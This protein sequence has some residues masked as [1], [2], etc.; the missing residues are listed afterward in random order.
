MMNDWAIRPPVS[1][2]P[3]A[4]RKIPDIAE[5]TKHTTHG[6]LTAT[7]VFMCVR[8]QSS[9]SIGQEPWQ[10]SQAWGGTQAGVPWTQRDA[11]VPPPPPPT[12]PGGSGANR[13]PEGSINASYQREEEREQPGTRAASPLLTEQ[14]MEAAREKIQAGAATDSGGAKVMLLRLSN[15]QNDV[16]F[17][18][19]DIASVLATLAVRMGVSKDHIVPQADQGG[20]GPFLVTVAEELGEVLVA[21]EEVE[22][23]H[24]DS[25]AEAIGRAVFAVQRL[26][27][28][29]RAMDSHTEERVRAR[30]AARRLESSRE[31]RERTYRFFLDGPPEMLV[32]KATD[33][34][35]HTALFARAQQTLLR[36]M[37]AYERSNATVQIDA[38]GHEL[39]QMI[40][41]IVRHESTSEQE[42]LGAIEWAKLKYLVLEEDMNPIKVRITRELADKVGVR[43]CCFLRECEGDGRVACAARSRAMRG[44]RLP[45]NFPSDARAQSKREKE[46]RGQ[47]RV[48]EGERVM[49]V[50]REAT[51]EKSSAMCKL[52]RQGRCLKHMFDT[53]QRPANTTCRFTHG[54]REQ[55]G[56][57]AC[58]FGDECANVG[59]PYRHPPD[60]QA[61]AVDVNGN[62]VIST[63]ASD[64]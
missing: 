42:F 32:M 16:F 7:V 52:Y 45:T 12:A 33:P 10:A 4:R 47:A 55:T 27:A 29:G 37:P 26:D 13:K 14:Q 54:T 49:E 41:F 25:G 43:P 50:V 53:Y 46:L 56:Q 35:R 34:A 15:P 1:R 20:K 23:L 57:I 2:G 44:V 48:R 17:N 62:L 6:N 21:E 36:A 60:R 59:C 61:K 58:H 51:R 39:N 19:G 63:S 40:V 18:T 9:W 11:S 30:R 38:T 5:R 24:V 64:D 28:Q 22:L 8:L 31:Q 3:Y